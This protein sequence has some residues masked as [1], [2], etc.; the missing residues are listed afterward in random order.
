VAADPAR[1]LRAL[2]D[3]VTRTAVAEPGTTPDPGVPTV[4]L[5]SGDVPAGPP[6]DATRTSPATH[7]ALDLSDLPALDDAVLDGLSPVGGRWLGDVPVLLLGPA[8]PTGPAGLAAALAGL[9]AAPAETGASRDRVAL[10][11]AELAG[12]DRRVADAERRVRELARRG[13]VEVPRSD[14]AAAGEPT[15]GGDTVRRRLRGMLGRD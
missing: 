9:A 14:P 3:S 11:E 2:G 6:A 5:L 4:L 15:Q 10:L 8:A 1:V 12:R 7:L 13:P